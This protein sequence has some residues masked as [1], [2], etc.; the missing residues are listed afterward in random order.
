M[1]QSKKKKKSVYQGFKEWLLNIIL[2]MVKNREN[3]LI[4]ML[5]T[6]DYAHIWERPTTIAE[7]WKLKL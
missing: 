5:G 6:N 2:V 1:F 4:A 3:Y 7:T